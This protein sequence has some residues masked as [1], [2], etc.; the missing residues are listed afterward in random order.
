MNMK[1]GIQAVILA[2]ALL[3]E[4][5]Y[6]QSSVT[7]YGLIDGFIGE[8]KALNG[9]TAVTTGN[10]GMTASYFGMRGTEDIGGGTSVIFDLEGY[11]NPENGAMGRTGFAGDGL[12]SRNAYV[13]L[14]GQYGTVTTGL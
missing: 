7:L 9:K 13:G 11:F 6:A 1:R 8:K 5:A 14:K 4:A 2:S 10:G 3:G 12:F